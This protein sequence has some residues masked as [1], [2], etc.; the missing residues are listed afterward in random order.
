MPFSSAELLSDLISDAIQKHAGAVGVLVRDV[1]P[2]EPGSLLARLNQLNGNGL[3]MR[4]AYL[5]AGG[6]AAASKLNLPPEV[7][8]TEVEQAERWRNDRALTALIVVIAHGD[9]AKLST[10]LWRAL[11]AQMK[12][13]VVG[14]GSWPRT[15]VSAWDS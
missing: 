5:R 13:K 14:G 6:A 15:I 9:E 7:F 10:G 3:P 4:I 1:P 2:P 11:L 12:F 8:S